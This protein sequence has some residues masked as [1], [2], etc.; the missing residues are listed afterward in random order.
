MRIILISFCQ[1]RLLLMV[2]AIHVT[3]TFQYLY[4]SSL[5]WPFILQSH[6]SNSQQCV[7]QIAW[8]SLLLIVQ[9][10]I[11]LLGIVDAPGMPSAVI[12]I[13]EYLH[14][15]CCAIAYYYIGYHVLLRQAGKHTCGPHKRHL[16]IFQ[17]FLYV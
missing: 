14:P 4:A 15:C 7:E 13:A 8:N 2:I 3:K 16:W 6:R 12:R 1:M 5:S 9:L 10:F 11:N 17:P